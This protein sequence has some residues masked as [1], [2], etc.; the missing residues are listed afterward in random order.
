MVAWRAPVPGRG[1]QEEHPVAQMN[2]YQLIYTLSI[3]S[4]NSK[5]LQRVNQNVRDT[6]SILCG[7]ETDYPLNHFLIEASG[8]SAA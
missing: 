1:M 3:Q 7:R 5:V 6:N 4:S 8:S 2:N